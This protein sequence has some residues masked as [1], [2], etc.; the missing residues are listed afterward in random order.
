MDEKDIFILRK[1]YENE[2]ISG[3]ELAS[4]LNISRMAINKRIKSLKALGYKIES[5]RKKGYELVDKDIIRVW[6][7]KDYIQSS[8]LF[9]EFI[10]LD[11]ID[12][13]N[14]YVKQNQQHLENAT[15]VYTERQTQ[16]RGRLLR[17]WVDI[18]KGIKMSILLK[19]ILFDLEKIVPLTLFTG[20]II[21]RVLRKYGV[22]SFIKWS[23]DI[24]LNGKKVCG[25]LSELSGEVEGL[26]S[27]IIGIGINVNAES[28]PEDIK[29]I[30]T[31]LKT[32]TSQDFDRTR[33]I[34]DILSEFERELPN[35]DNYGFSYFRD[36]YKSFCL[37]FGKEILINGERMLCRDIGENGELV[38]EKDGEI[39]E[40]SSGEVLMRF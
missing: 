32:E 13:T 39:I 22:N 5:A 40:I 36:E 26:G 16:G 14:T 11:E 9:K 15:V 19:L 27:I 12:S 37:N 28:V 21:N 34:I 30:A 17:K 31:T 6:E 23:N 1:L 10:Y 20:L 33:L 2:Y 8:N 7:I 38:C 18:E 35:F 24:Y 29:D 25:I 3:E 4:F